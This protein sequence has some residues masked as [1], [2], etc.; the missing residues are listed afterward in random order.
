LY[1]FPTVANPLPSTPCLISWELVGETEVSCKLAL[2]T[3][4]SRGKHFEKSG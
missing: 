2:R 4:R 1:K 3:R